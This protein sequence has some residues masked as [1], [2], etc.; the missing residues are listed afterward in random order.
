MMM[1][2]VPFHF[3]LNVFHAVY[4]LDCSTAILLYCYECRKILPPLALLHLDH[5]EGEVTN[6]PF[7][8]VT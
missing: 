7:F 3:P 8:G 4:C 6:V 5:R 1:F 2:P